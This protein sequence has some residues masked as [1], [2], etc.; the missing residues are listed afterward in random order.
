[1]CEPGFVFTCFGG[2]RFAFLDFKVDGPAVADFRA[3]GFLFEV[4]FELDGGLGA[5][6]VFWQFCNPS[7]ALKMYLQDSNTKRNVCTRNSKKY[8]RRFTAD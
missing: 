4:G 1:M 5:M 3:C 2:G 8:D 6:I 7:F